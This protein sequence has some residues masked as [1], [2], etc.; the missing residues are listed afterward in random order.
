MGAQHIFLPCVGVIAGLM[1]G[2]LLPNMLHSSRFVGAAV[3]QLSLLI[4]CIRSA[5]RIVCL[6]ALG[7][8]LPWTRRCEVKL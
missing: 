4:Q 8:S 1:A 3:K 6:G 2:R 7:V 5:R